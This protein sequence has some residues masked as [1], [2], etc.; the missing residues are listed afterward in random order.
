MPR[1]AQQVHVIR[2]VDQYVSQ[3]HEP[4]MVRPPVQLIPNRGVT[5]VHPADHSFDLL[6]PAEEV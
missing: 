5:Q 2:L 4:S 1:W 3:P 6:A